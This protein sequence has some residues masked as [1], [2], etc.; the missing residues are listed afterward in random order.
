MITVT[1]SCYFWNNGYLID[2]KLFS[3]IINHT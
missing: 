2:Y 1:I 3:V